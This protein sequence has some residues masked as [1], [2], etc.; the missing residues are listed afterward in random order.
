MFEGHHGMVQTRGDGDDRMVTEDVIKVHGLPSSAETG[1]LQIGI[2]MEYSSN[3]Q[4][5]HKKRQSLDK[6]SSGRE[7]CPA[8]FI[9]K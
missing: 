2:D 5:K 7:S 9:P 4:D 8:D 1:L 3:P 6:R